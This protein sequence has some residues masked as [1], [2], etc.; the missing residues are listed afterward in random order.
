MITYLSS[1]VSFFTKFLTMP[2][3]GIKMDLRENF[4]SKYVPSSIW[5]DPDLNTGA[6]YFS[7]LPDEVLL[8]IL[9]YLDTGS[10]WSIAKTCK[11]FQK[12]SFV[13]E[14]WTYRKKEDLPVAYSEVFCMMIVLIGRVQSMQRRSKP[15][16]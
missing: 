9:S 11:R 1:L 15:N 2:L 13:P 14:L 16:T 6:D 10:L 5:I 8:N 12:C 7:Q 4:C 3:V